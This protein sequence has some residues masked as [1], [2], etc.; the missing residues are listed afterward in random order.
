MQLTWLLEAPNRACFGSQV[1]LRVVWSRLIRHPADAEVV[2]SV[3]TDRVGR[4]AE[5]VR[6]IIGDIE[7]QESAGLSE[8]ALQ[9]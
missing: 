2:Y 1:R 8:T 4:L 7:S 6:T 5:E 3:S 9:A